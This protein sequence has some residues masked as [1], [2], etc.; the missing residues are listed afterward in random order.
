MTIWSGW[1]LRQ[2]LSMRTED[3]WYSLTLTYHVPQ[4]ERLPIITGTSASQSTDHL[5]RFGQ[6]IAEAPFP[7]PNYNH[8][9]TPY[10]HLEDFSRE[11]DY[12]HYLWGI[13]FSIIRDDSIDIPNHFIRFFSYVEFYQK[14]F[15]GEISATKPSIPTSTPTMSQKDIITAI[16]YEAVPIDPFL[17]VTP[18]ETYM[19]IK[20]KPLDDWA[21]NQLPRQLTPPP[22][23]DI[24]DAV[25]TP[26]DCDVCTRSFNHYHFSYNLRRV[27]TLGN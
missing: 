21:I 5:G 1:Q 17:I 2:T 27:E 11:T 18:D 13:C 3:T 19:W 22:Q 15:L 6:V 7:S 24:E 25:P 26:C 10:T 9:S 16:L 4:T 23:Y 14:V 20:S 8:S 12:C